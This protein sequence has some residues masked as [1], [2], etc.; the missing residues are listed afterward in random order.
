MSLPLLALCG[1]LAGCGNDERKPSTLERADSALATMSSATISMTFTATAANA[2]AHVTQPVGFSVEGP[3]DMEAGSIYPVFDIMY[4]RMI[5]GEQQEMHTR[6]DGSR[7]VV[8]SD[9]ETVDVPAEL[10]EPLRKRDAPGAGLLKGVV[11]AGWVVNPAASKG[12]T[13]DGVST[14]QVTG[15]ADAADVLS[16]LSALVGQ[17]GATAD[18]QPLAGKS[19]E[20]VRSLLRSSSV[21]VLVGDD[22]VPRSVHVE[23][24]FGSEVSP[25]LA[26]ALG[27]FAAANLLI[28]LS[29]T[30]PNTPVPV[31]P[32][33][34]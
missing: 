1:A 12:P 17:I 6:S 9:G 3:F 14:T 29:I 32:L 19:A 8:V 28:D 16:D 18:L 22:D 23:M 5:G 10:A 27:P 21:T 31:P 11:L 7:L 26:T 25:E 24:S 30:G 13:V 33:D 15:T 34:Q 4:R 20:R 2:A